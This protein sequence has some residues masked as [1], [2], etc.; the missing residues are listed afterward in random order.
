MSSM[1]G[2][3]ERWY[4]SAKR[5]AAHRRAV[6]A[7]AAVSFIE[8]SVFP[9]PPDVMLIPM[10]QARRERAWYYAFVCTVASVLGGIA[11]YAIGWF[12]F[13]SIAQPVL[14][15]LGKADSIEVFEKMAEEHGAM[16][17]FGAGL[18]PFPYKVITIMSGAL[19][20]SLPIFIIASVLS[21]SIRFF[22]VAGIVW[23][24]GDQA[25]QLIKKHFAATTIGIFGLV[26]AAWAVWHF[27][28]SG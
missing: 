24:F 18:T 15:Q 4:E 19:K 8:S 1:P 11:G 16:A 28:F 20:L 17:V 25:E 14:D 10:V 26:F 2:F 27:G 9:I 13:D 22:L 6:P 21:R 5:L 3:L 23:K 12:L 7:L